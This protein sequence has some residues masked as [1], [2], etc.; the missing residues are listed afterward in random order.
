MAVIA[1]RGVSTGRQ[2]VTYLQ[3]AT[4][5]TYHSERISQT[6]SR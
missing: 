3:V 5:T 4:T 2:M 1:G 6:S